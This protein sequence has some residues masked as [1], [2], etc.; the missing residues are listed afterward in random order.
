MKIKILRQNR[1]GSA[2]AQTVS[3]IPDWAVP[4][5]Q[6]V[7]NQATAQYNAGNLDNVAGV[8]AIQQQAFDQ[9]GNISATTNLGVSEMGQ[10][11][12][13]LK[14]LASQGAYNPTALKEAAIEEAGQATAQLGRQYGAQG[15]LGSARQ[16]VVQGAQNAMTAAK[17]A[18]IDK[19]LADTSFQQKLAA[20]QGLASSVGG[21]QQLAAGGASALA[22]L[23]SEQRNITQQQADASWQ[24]LQ[25]YASTIYGNPARQQAVGGGGGK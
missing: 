17:F 9:A 18:E 1:K 3:S 6:N 21:A 8:S 22:N 11:A 24:A 12:Q 15:T 5:L 23:G 4:Y 19:N 13:R 20:E 25:R 2:P 10:Q 7:G 14:D 16:A